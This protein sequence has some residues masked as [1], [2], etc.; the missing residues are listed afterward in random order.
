VSCLR[1]PSPRRSLDS[2]D[3]F[4][5]GRKHIGV[6]SW[7]RVA[8]R[9]SSRPV[10]LQSQSHCNPWRAIRVACGR[11]PAARSAATVASR[12][13][14]RHLLA[15]SDNS[16]FSAARS[17]PHRGCCTAGGGFDP[18]SGQR[19]SRVPVRVVL[20]NPCGQHRTKTTASQSRPSQGS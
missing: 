6:V 10:K 19:Q 17:S 9:S 1:T 20:P 4:S 5:S 11:Q 14:R 15:V 13:A 2:L 7:F 3:H 8:K 18:R 12:S 16:Q